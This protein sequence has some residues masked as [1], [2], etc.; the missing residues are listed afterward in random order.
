MAREVW[1]AKESHQVSLAGWA[2]GTIVGILALVLVGMFGY[3]GL[4][5]LRELVGF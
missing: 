2:V 4:L 3:A 5:W 1:L